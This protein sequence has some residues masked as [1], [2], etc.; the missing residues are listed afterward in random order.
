MAKG[1][2]LIELLVVVTIIIVLLALLTPAMDKAIYQAELLQCASNLKSIGSGATIYAAEFKRFYPDRLNANNGWLTTDLVYNGLDDRPVLR[3][4]MPINLFVDPFVAEVDLT[5]PSARVQS[6]FTSLWFDTKYVNHSGMEKLGDRFTWTGT[7]PAGN[8]KVHRLSLLASDSDYYTD[9]GGGATY[10][11]HQ[12]ETG[13]MTNARTDTTDF[14]Q[15]YWVV[16]NGV[17]RGPVDYNFAYAD[18]SVERLERLKT[19]KVAGEEDERVVR[20]PILNN[21]QSAATWYQQVPWR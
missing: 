20:V 13:T 11:S 21:A 3:G 16:A 18:G 19:N 9:Q 7:D 4:H 14:I 1:F 6:S 2:T 12:D 15:S 17:I 5:R 8:P 10:G